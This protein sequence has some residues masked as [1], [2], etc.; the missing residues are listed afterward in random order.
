MNWAYSHSCPPLLLLFVK[1]WPF[2]L[3]GEQVKLSEC[4]PRSPL[5]SLG[6]QIQPE[7]SRRGHI[8]W[9]Q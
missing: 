7:S 5:W 1:A 3:M 6:L 4:N 8:Q 9:D 2:G